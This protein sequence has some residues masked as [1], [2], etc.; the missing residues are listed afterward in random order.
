MLVFETTPMAETPGTTINSTQP[1]INPKIVTTLKTMPTF[2]RVYE[3]TA[4][5]E[6]YTGEE[7]T[8]TPSAIAEDKDIMVKESVLPA[9]RKDPEVRAPMKA[10]PEPNI[11]VQSKASAR[12]SSRKAKE[13]IRKVVAAA[14]AA[15]K[16]ENQVNSRASAKL[17]AKKLKVEKRIAKDLKRA[18]TEKARQRSAEKRMARANTNRKIKN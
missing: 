12:S 5:V 14:A 15:V 3:T 9:V 10:A 1:T 17:E 13:A 7:T 18:L 6:L 8:T 4:M 2:Q 11:V 16:K